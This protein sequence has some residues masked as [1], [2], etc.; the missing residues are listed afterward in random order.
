[1]QARKL[2]EI[3]PSTHRPVHLVCDSAFGSFDEALYF[4]EKGIHVTYSMNCDPKAYL[5]DLLAFACPTETGRVA[6]V[7]LADQKPPALASYYCAIDD[8]GK[9]NDLRTL[10]TSFSWE[11]D[12]GEEGQVIA[13]TE[14]QISDDGHL[15]Y[16]TLWA[17]GDETWEPV[18]SFMDDDG[19]FTSPFLNFAG[20]DDIKAALE[21]LTV[22][23]LEV[24]CEA[25]N[26]SKA[27]NKPYVVKRIVQK[28]LAV[29]ADNLGWAKEVASSVVGV[30][31][32][33]ACKRIRSFYT[34][35][36]K[37]LDQ[38]DQAWY[39]A[40]YNKREDSW[41]SAFT[42]AL[43]MDSIINARSAYCEAVGSSEPVKAFLT[44]LIADINDYVSK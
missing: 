13:V 24:I 14:S 6:I 28:T 26:F 19:K 1:M 8:K 34:R 15:E 37:A 44:G 4:L 25:Q 31:D 2:M 29:K 39:E 21:G 36:Y 42:W 43:I 9:V 17:D 11:I 7:P 30:A 38:F 33:E 23:E 32:G 3:F 35:N 41:L 27:G 5:W 16:K 22:A 10:T 40:F 20:E 12:N 18:S